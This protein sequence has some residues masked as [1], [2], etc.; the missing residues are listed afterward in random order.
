M[1]V[2][3]R[4]DGNPVGIVCAAE[5]YLQELLAVLPVQSLTFWQ[6]WLCRIVKGTVRCGGITEPKAEVGNTLGQLRESS[7][8][9]NVL[10]CLA[11]LAAIC[12]CCQLFIAANFW[13]DRCRSSLAAGRYSVTAQM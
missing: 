5:C 7:R 6:I 4:H 11:C 10:L 1:V 3:Q 12:Q 13:I 9:A 8:Q 2:S